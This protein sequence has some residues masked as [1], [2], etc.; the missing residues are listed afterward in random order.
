MQIQE[1]IDAKDSGR[2]A[3]LVQTY[4]N[5]DGNDFTALQS[6]FAAIFENRVPEIS[7]EP[8]SERDHVIL[9]SI[10]QLLSACEIVNGRIKITIAPRTI[11]CDASNGCLSAPFGNSPI[12]W[13]NIIINNAIIKTHK[14]CIVSS[15]KNEGPWLI[16]W[17]AHYKALGVDEIIIYFNDSDDGSVELLRRLAD[18]NQIVAVQNI[19]SVDV[20]PQRQAFAHALASLRLAYSA[21]WVA[22]IDV[23]EFLVADEPLND[24]DAMIQSVCISGKHRIDCIAINW[25]WFADS[26]QF[27]WEDGLVVDRFTAA[28]NHF[29]KKCIFRPEAATSVYEI[30][31]PTLVEGA[32]AVDSLGG[33]IVDLKVNCPAKELPPLRLNHYFAK[34]FK[35]FTLKKLRGRG[36]R[37]F[38][39]EL[40]N[41]DSFMWASVGT[42]E[43]P[44]N[45][46]IREKLEAEVE[47]LSAIAGVAELNCGAVEKAHAK[48]VEMEKEINLRKIYEEVK[49]S[50]SNARALSKLNARA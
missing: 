13:F 4:S 37:A 26:D 29:M 1:L 40:R 31:Y 6:A 16:E 49:R 27:D 11:Q 34:S 10:R 28:F 2:L 24:I 18:A 44:M 32:R 9:A 50:D 30:H 7:L 3:R 25:D 41:F 23:D 21:E 22:F 46:V 39:K 14:C 15:I 5:C 36:A 17:I 19:V 8:R 43:R 48:L 45:K 38:G 20:S 12:E 47:K 33:E 42:E 35:E